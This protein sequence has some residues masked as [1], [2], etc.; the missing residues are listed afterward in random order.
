MSS[1][2]ARFSNLCALAAGCAVRDRGLNVT[3]K[4]TPLFTVTVSRWVDVEISDI[5]AFT[6]TRGLYKS[7][8]EENYLEFQPVC[9]TSSSQIL[10]GPCLNKL[11]PYVPSKKK[12]FVTNDCP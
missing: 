5:N 9:R 4:K 12:L 7:G 3:I 2:R 1:K 6:G 8:L 11:H 10:F